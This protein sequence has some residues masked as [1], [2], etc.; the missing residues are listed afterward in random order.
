MGFNLQQMAN[1]AFR[2]VPFA[3]RLG[4]HKQV[5]EPIEIRLQVLW[6]HPRE[7]PKAPLQPRA[8][9]VRHGHRLDVQ[10]GSDTPAPCTRPA[11]FAAFIGTGC[12]FSVPCTMSDSHARQLSSASSMRFGEGFRWP[13]TFATGFS[14]TSIA[15]QCGSFPSKGRACGPRRI[16]GKGLC[17]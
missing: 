2:F 11:R 7:L 16:H 10:G 9:V 1:C 17:R 13:R 8:Q 3:L 14:W 4:H 15:K 6:A 12:D 5:N